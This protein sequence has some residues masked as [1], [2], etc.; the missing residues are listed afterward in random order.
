[1]RITKICCGVLLAAGVMIAVGCADR[2]KLPDGVTAEKT[3]LKVMLDE[4]PTTGYTWVLDEY[5]NKV[6]RLDN[7]SYETTA[8]EGTVGAGGVH[9]YNFTGLKEGNVTLIFRY[10]RS[11]E[12]KDTAI[13]VREFKVELDSKGTVLK[14]SD[15]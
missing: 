12:S 11:W 2:M 15:K 4:N 9:S 13:D 3:H 1:M 8:K 14:V 5:D 10:Y 6:L 7:D